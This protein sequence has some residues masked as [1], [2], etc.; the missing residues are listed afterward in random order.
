VWTLW[1][2]PEAAET[3]AR[4]LLDA[5]AGA[6][7]RMVGHHALD[8]LRVEVGRPL[9]GVDFDDGHFPQE[10][11]LEEAAVSYTK[12]CYLGQE[13]VAR[14][15]YRGGVNRH[16]RGLVM[17]GDGPSAAE[18][19]GRPVLH[20]GRPAGTLTSATDAGDGRRLGLSILHRRAEP[21]AEV[22]VEGAGTARVVE[23][24]FG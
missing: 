19:P 20:D 7:V 4:G 2:A 12:G 23:L 1:T 17:E 6:G 10:T 22:E 3:L 15:H 13:V 5:G 11:G 21:G 18:L 9:Y 16:L 14:I 8:R 24:P